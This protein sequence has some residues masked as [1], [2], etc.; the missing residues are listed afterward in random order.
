MCDRYRVYLCVHEFLHMCGAWLRM[1]VAPTAALTGRTRAGS[2]PVDAFKGKWAGMRQ[3][4]ASE[5]EDASNAAAPTGVDL[6]VLRHVGTASVAVPAG[7][8]VRTAAAAAAGSVSCNAHSLEPPSAQV[9]PRLVRGHVDP[10]LDVL[11]RGADVDWATAEALAIGSLMSSGYRVR[12]S[13]QDSQRGTFSHRHGALVC[14]VRA[15]RP[16]RIAA[17]RARIRAFVVFSFH[18]RPAVRAPARAEHR[19][20]TRAA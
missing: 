5:M 10:R 13:G 11:K 3:A 6:D 9:H 18:D 16:R 14:Q 2:G 15:P 12:I 8:T 20:R 7:F 1:W 4:A 17:P 19:A